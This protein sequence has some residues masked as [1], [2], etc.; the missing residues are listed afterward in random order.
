MKRCRRER[1]GRRGAGGGFSLVE[2][3]IVVVIIGILAA[4]AVPKFANASQSARE[5]TV[6]RNLQ[7]VR[8]QL[9]VYR[10][11]HQDV[12]PGYPGGDTAQTPTEAEAADQLMK[13]TDGQ[14]F[15]SAVQTDTFRY[16]PYVTGLPENA[17]NGKVTWKILGPSDPIVADGLTG[18]LYQ[19]STGAFRANVV[20]NDSAGKSI[21]DY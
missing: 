3:L 18:W 8:T 11:H 1:S 19:P 15:T 12:W 21:V 9:G 17:L 5:N 2:I 13:F 14:G 4:I 6:K 7:L 10:T 20:G 16:G